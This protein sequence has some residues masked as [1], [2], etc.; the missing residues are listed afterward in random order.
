MLNPTRDTK[1][2]LSSRIALSGAL[3]LAGIFGL[4]AAILLP[5]K[6]LKNPEF[7]QPLP[8]IDGGSAI[9]VTHESA[10]PPLPVTSSQDL[11][12][13]CSGNVTE[14]RSFVVFRMGTAVIVDEPCEDPLAAACQKLSACSEPDVRFITE[15]TREGDLIVTFKE[16]VF[17]RF[18]GGELSKL[19]YWQ[20][21]TVS[22]LLTPAERAAV[23]EG[24][25][26]NR[27]ARFGLL[28]RR[29]MLE[30]AANPVPVKIIR[31]KHRAL[32]SN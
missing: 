30:D 29:R 28:A 11:I 24:W 19:A 14:T 7:A 3:L 18:S 32:A 21:H 2:P 31:A 1:T 25:T 26:P 5:V 15:P 9:A 22:E 27:N 8:S 16:P 23:A 13:F 4:G 20:E 17:H 10:A 12:R 6:K